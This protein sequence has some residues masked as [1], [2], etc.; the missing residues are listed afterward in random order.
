MMNIEIERRWLLKRKPK[1]DY[2][3]RLDIVQLYGSNSRGNFRLRKS[4]S[5]KEKICRYYLTTKK[6]LSYGT[7][8]EL[9]QEI[10]ADSYKRRVRA[11]RELKSI[12]K[13]RFILYHK[14]LKY[15]IDMYNSI[16]LVVLEIELLNIHMPIKL[17]RK[18]SREIIME[19]TGIEELSNY[20]M[21]E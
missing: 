21:S 14:D 15:E 18:V 2:D 6:K 8:A 12:S 4:Y 10:T 19:I 11:N 3:D 20:R 17:H 16:S 1:V 9:D 5:N 13:R 7:F